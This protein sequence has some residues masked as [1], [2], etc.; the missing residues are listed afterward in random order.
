MSGKMMFAGS[1][2]DLARSVRNRLV[3]KLSGGLWPFFTQL[4]TWAVG[5]SM[6]KASRLLTVFA[7]ALALTAADLGLAALGL[8]IAEIL[9]A[10]TEN[11]IGQ[12]IIAA[13][14]EELEDV[15]NQAFRLFFLCCSGLFLVQALIGAGF[16]LITGEVE[17]F[18]MLSVL[19]TPFLFMPW[20]LVPCFRAM[21]AG[22]LKATASVA[23]SQMTLANL[24]TALAV[25]LWPDPLAVALPKLATAPFWMLAMRRLDPW[26][27]DASGP[28]APVGSFLRF[29]APILGVE[30]LRMLRMQADKLLVGAILGM[31]ALGF[32]FFAFSAGLSLTNALTT[33]LTTVAFPHLCKADPGEDR[34]QALRRLTFASLAVLGPLVLLQAALAPLYVPM[35]FGERWEDATAAVSILCLAA[36]PGL[37]WTM[38]SQALRADGRAGTEFR[39][40]LGLTVCLLLVTALI[41][42]LGLTEVAL[43]HLLCLSLFQFSAALYVLRGPRSGLCPQ[44]V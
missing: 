28:R 20:G 29:G 40:T 17:L 21:R 1:F 27:Y 16:W 8:A 41:A 36:L 7:L 6:V 11:G 9:R 42:P 14:D 4:A 31:E 35:L 32:Y 15:S 43:A 34:Q 23:A 18:V 33:A 38:A 44:G 10:F 39:V 25:T 24:L 5:E 30:V 26:R 13:K 19:A 22:R 12:K 3:Q 37:L 2:P